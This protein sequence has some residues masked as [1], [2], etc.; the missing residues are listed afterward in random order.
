MRC[1]RIS[2]ADPMGTD[3]SH[4]ADGTQQTGTCNCCMNNSLHL[5][6]NSLHVTT[7]FHTCGV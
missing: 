1:L 3:A 5:K 7:L 6:S 2:C 4:S